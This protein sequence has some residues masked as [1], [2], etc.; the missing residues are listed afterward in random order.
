MEAVADSLVAMAEVAVLEEVP[1]AV[2]A[3][4]GKSQSLFFVVQL[5]TQT[6]GKTILA[7]HASILEVLTVPTDYQAKLQVHQSPQG[8]LVKKGLSKS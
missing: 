2:S 6:L 8:S 5:L 3:I 4:L 7:D 1:V